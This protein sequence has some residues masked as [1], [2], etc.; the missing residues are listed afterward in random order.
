M[1]HRLPLL[2]LLRLLYFL[3]RL[4]LLQVEDYEKLLFNVP[5]VSTNSSIADNLNAK[6]TEQ[7]GSFSCHWPQ[8]FFQQPTLRFVG[9]CHFTFADGGDGC[10]HAA[11]ALESLTV[12]TCQQ[13]NTFTVNQG[14]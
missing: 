12:Q 4:L 11:T 3:L 14:P 8:C 1:L 6:V 2:R 10:C 13:Y 5:T 7:N 9:C